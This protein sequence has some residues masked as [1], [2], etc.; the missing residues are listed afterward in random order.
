MN[1]W[2]DKFRVTIWGESHGQQ[3]GV[4]IDGVRAG[5]ALKEED[6]LADLSRRK[7]GGTGTT[8]RTESDAPHI[9]SGREL[10]I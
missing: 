1:S 3:V 2:G 5:I 7:A 10:Q 6:F 9:V 4:S 8:T